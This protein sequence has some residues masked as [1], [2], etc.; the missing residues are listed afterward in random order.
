MQFLL[1]LKESSAIG[2]IWRGIRFLAL[3]MNLYL[4]FTKMFVKNFS[5]L[6]ASSEHF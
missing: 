1:T 4:E 3:N 2:F 6:F 5:P